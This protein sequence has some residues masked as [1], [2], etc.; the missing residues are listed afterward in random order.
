MDCCATPVEKGPGAEIVEAATVASVTANNLP[1]PVVIDTPRAAAE[2]PP[3]QASQIEVQTAPA[4]ADVPANVPANAPAEAPASPV[5][6]RPL[7]KQ[8]TEK[9]D[10]TV[11]HIEA[12]KRHG[13]NPGASLPFWFVDM[14]YLIDKA[15]PSNADGTIDKEE[16]LEILHDAAS[17]KTARLANS[18]EMEIKNQS[19]EMLEILHDAASLKTAR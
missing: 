13:S 9:D 4:A 12:L 15:D 1:E 3:I 6:P 18:A 7:T 11:V 14:L 5:S 16:M 8:E 2:A 19:P 10:A 17:L